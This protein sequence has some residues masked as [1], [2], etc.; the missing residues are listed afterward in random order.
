MADVNLAL[1]LVS[2]VQE[3]RTHRVRKFSFGDG[4][5]QITADGVNTRMS[6]YDVTTRPLGS[7]DALV[8]RNALDD[9][10]IGDYFLMTLTPFSQT[11]RRYRLKDNSYSRQFLVAGATNPNITTNNP[12]L[13]VFQFSLI[14]ANI[15]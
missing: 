1:D 11:Q 7:T 6:E 5:E 12:T 8:L 2:N 15:D 10:A 14:E 4:Y 3:K 13:E 9:V